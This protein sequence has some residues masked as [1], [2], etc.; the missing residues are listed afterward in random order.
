MLETDENY[1]PEIKS[2]SSFHDIKI[3]KSALKEYLLSHS[4]F[5][6]EFTK[7]NSQLSYIDVSN[8]DSGFLL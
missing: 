6:E 1:K 2:L 5:E 7:T 3:V 8:N 4:Y